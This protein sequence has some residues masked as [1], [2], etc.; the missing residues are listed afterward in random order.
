[1]KEI[2]EIDFFVKNSLSKERYEHSKRVA[3]E[4]KK[5]AIHYHY[6]P[7]KAYLAGLVHDVAKEY[8]KLQNE[9]IIKKYQLS[10]DL[11][12]DYNKKILHSYIGAIVV[13]EKFH[14]L[15]CL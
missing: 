8:T 14:L 1:M 6:D 15:F 3:E 2:E 4:A 10:Q 9:E 12:K 11:L 13:K 7:E 5:L